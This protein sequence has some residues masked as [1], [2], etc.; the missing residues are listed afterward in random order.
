[1]STNSEGLRDGHVAAPVGS[2]L[3]SHEKALLGKLLEKDPGLARMYRGALHALHQKENP[4]RLVLAAHEIRE[5]MEKV[6]RAVDIAVK[7]DRPLGEEVRLLCQDWK[8]V[9][10][11]VHEKEGRLCCEVMAK[12]KFVQSM[13]EFLERYDGNSTSRLEKVKVLVRKLDPSGRQIPE[14]LEGQHARFWG[15]LRD[16][17]V[18]VAHHGESSE[19]ELMGY[20]NEL[21]NFLLARLIPRTFDDMDAI[22][23]LLDEAETDA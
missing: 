13:E 19:E 22:D 10:P 18:K 7:P 2:V 6:P 21:E 1:M 9:K 17:F 5:L 12:L 23:A 11:L 15:M 16:Y 8:R 14:P 3:K 4:E 20:L